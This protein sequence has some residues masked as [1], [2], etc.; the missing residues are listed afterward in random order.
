MQYSTIINLPYRV[1]RFS[2]VPKIEIILI[3][4]KDLPSAGA[5]EA[6]IIG[7]APAIRNAILDATGKELNNL[8]M[9][10]NGVVA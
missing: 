7:V 2:D 3:D 8:P 6:S 10:P 5:G 4:R 9:I 1:P